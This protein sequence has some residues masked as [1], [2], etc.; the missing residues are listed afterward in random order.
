MPTYPSGKG[1]VKAV[2]GEIM[3]AGSLRAIRESTSAAGDHHQLR[4]DRDGRNRARLPPR[5]LQGTSSVSIRARM[6]F[7]GAPDGNRLW[8]IPAPRQELGP[9]AG[10]RLDRVPCN[11]ER[12]PAAASTGDSHFGVPGLR[13]FFVSSAGKRIFSRRRGISIRRLSISS[14]RQSSRKASLGFTVEARYAGMSAAPRVADANRSA[15]CAIVTG[16]VA[17]TPNN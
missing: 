13:L 10:D 2:E 12:F 16:S 1:F 7:R 15:D 14:I 5:R 6:D 11:R 17:V 9:L 4:P 8:L 3:T